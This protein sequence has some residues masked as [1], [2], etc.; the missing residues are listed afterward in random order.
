MFLIDLFLK[1]LTYFEENTLSNVSYSFFLNNT[2]RA[3]FSRNKV[4][5][6]LNTILDKYIKDY[7]ALFNCHFNTLFEQISFNSIL[8]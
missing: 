3:I 7:K 1:A 4:T 6:I 8:E 5:T 2:K